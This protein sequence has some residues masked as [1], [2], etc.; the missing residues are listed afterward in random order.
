MWSSA[1]PEPCSAV[2]TVQDE[3]GS[4]SLWIAKENVPAIWLLHISPTCVPP[5]AISV[6]MSSEVIGGTERL[7]AVPQVLS[8]QVGAQTV[9]FTQTF[10]PWAH[11]AQS[12]PVESL[13]ITSVSRR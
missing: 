3:S 10:P 1:M 2:S 12:R 11:V 5:N 7:N 13:S 8:S 4:P 9:A 6:E